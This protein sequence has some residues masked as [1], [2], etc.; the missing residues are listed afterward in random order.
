V[1]ETETR[2]NLIDPAL[3]AAGWGVVEASRVRR[4]AITLGRLHGAGVR[5]A[6]DI[7]NTVLTDGNHRLR[8]PLLHG[9]KQNNGHPGCS[10][11]QNTHDLK[12]PGQTDSGGFPGKGFQGFS[13]GYR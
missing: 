5:A 2:A 3:K 8:R 4:E 10:V 6:Q 9:I 7:A 12:L 11:L 1:N 13:H